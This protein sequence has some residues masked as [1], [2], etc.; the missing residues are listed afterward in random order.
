MAMTVGSGNQGPQSEV[1]VTP[2]IDVLLVLLIIFMVITPLAPKGLDAA[3]PQPEVR[4]EVR[5]PVA[6]A[7]VVSV[8]SQHRLRINQQP[9][10]LAALGDRLEKIFKARNERVVFVKGDADANFGEVADVIDAAR[11]AGIDRVGLIT[12]AIK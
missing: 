10:T 9:T 6:T 5:P 7:V 3:V 8:D 12:T 4:P 11:G 2:L 1:N